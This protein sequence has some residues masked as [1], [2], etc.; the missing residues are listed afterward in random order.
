M[1]K[2]K[3]RGNVGKKCRQLEREGREERERG[4]GMRS[5]IWERDRGIKG[6]G[7]VRG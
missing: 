2:R 7:E 4:G 6:R 5:G 3:E 1:G